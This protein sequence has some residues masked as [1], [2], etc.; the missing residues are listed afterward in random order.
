MGL[1]KGNTVKVNCDVQGDLAPSV[2]NMKGNI[3]GRLR[4]MDVDGDPAFSVRLKHRKNARVM[5][6]SELKKTNE[7][8]SSF[9]S[10]P[11]RER[12]VKRGFFG[13]LFG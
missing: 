1:R 11:R 9:S 8:K 7:R 2:I 5:W 3:I 10:K 13:R 4:S 6:A 12:G